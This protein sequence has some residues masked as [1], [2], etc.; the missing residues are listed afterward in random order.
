MAMKACKECGN[1]ISS[2]AKKCPHCGKDQR[3]WFLQH[4]IITAIL[5]IAVLMIIGS[6]GGE[7]TDT[8]STSNK[9][10]TNETAVTTKGQPQEP[11]MVVTVAKLVSDLDNNAL[12]ASNTYKGEYVE[13]TGT[14]VNIDSSGGYFTLEPY[15]DS[16]TF[17]NVQCFI[18]EEHLD[19]VAKFT[20]NQQ[21]TVVGTITDVG[22]I[23]GYSLEVETIK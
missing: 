21:V 3:N 7:D 15:N 19:A 14:L 10:S 23:M 8:P 20:D 9:Q 11:P 2:D 4:K 12:N 22:E 13:V 17:T 5:A 18:E 1:E 6:M 16:F